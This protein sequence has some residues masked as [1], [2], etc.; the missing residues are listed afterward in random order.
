M[1]VYTS[2]SLYAI[3]DGGSFEELSERELGLVSNSSKRPSMTSPRASRERLGRFL[4]TKESYSEVE[5][6]EAGFGEEDVPGGV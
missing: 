1:R 5:G 4:Q 6:G 2:E 3:E